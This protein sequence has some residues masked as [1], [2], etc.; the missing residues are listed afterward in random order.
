M[1]KTPAA[2][3]RSRTAAN[4]MLLIIRRTICSKHITRPRRRPTSVMAVSGDGGPWNTPTSSS[5]PRP[6]PQHLQRP[7]RRLLLRR[8]LGLAV[9]LGHALAA[10]EHAH[11]EFALVVRSPGPLQLVAGLTHLVHLRVVQQAALG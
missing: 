10:D 4:P 11:R 2:T 7:L 9:P 6:L 8:L 1:S 3:T 5:L